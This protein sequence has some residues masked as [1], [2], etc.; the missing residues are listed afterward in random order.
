M[1][2]F[3][4][5]VPPSLEGGVVVTPAWFWVPFSSGGPNVFAGD[6][7]VR[8]LGG[9]LEFVRPVLGAVLG[10]VGVGFDKTLAATEVSHSYR[11]L[12]HLYQVINLSTLIFFFL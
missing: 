1:A 9:V 12:V 5:V 4:R 2:T 3:R 6:F 8:F 7:G 11:Q 10:L